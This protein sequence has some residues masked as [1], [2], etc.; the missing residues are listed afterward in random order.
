MRM[1][2]NADADSMR[3]SVQMEKMRDIGRLVE[4]YSIPAREL[5]QSGVWFPRSRRRGD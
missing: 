3:R 4:K 1:I 2:E 5:S